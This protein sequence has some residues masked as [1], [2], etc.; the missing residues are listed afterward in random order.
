MIKFITK[1]IF[2][3][4]IVVSITSTMVFAEDKNITNNSVYSVGKIISDM[5]IGTGQLFTI[6]KLL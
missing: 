5:Y 1:L 2:T 6:V 3:L 4:F